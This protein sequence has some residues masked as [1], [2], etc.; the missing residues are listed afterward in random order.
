MSNFIF[1]L[2][3]EILE[4]WIVNDFSPLLFPNKVAV[5]V[6]LDHIDEHGLGIES[7]LLGAN[8]AFLAQS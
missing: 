5:K 3:G 7:A 6:L 8:N 4:I 2:L 1:D